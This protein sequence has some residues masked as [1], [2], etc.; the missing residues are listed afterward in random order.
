[1]LGVHHHGLVS[2]PGVLGKALG[3]VLRH[4]R[5]Q[6]EAPAAGHLHQRVRDQRGQR[7]GWCLHHRM[8]RDPR[9]AAAKSAQS[10]QRLPVNRVK[11]LPGEVQRGA[12]AVVA[13]RLAR[14]G[15]GQRVERLRQIGQNRGRIVH[16]QRRCGQLD[17]ERPA[18]DTLDQLDASR[19]LRHQVKARVQHPD[20]RLQQL[21]RVA[22]Q[23]LFERS[24]FTG[25]SLKPFDPE[26]P[27]AAGVQR[28][29]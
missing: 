21:Q 20:A 14:R 15:R 16:G 17:G 3:R 6:H 11:Q 10:G 25:G 13:P 5:V 8:S 23:G 9:E 19:P 22:A 18:A 12:H 28:R 27:F 2:L 7:G 24:H 26:Q 29:L 4:Q 1:M